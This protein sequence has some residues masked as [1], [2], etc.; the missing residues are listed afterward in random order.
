MILKDEKITCV[1]GTEVLCLSKKLAPAF[2][3]AVFSF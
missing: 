2:V 3:M 1:S